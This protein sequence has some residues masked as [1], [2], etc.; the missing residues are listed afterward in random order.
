MGGLCGVWLCGEQHRPCTPCWR[1]VSGGPNS[2]FIFFISMHLLHYG[3]NW[4][5][6]CGQHFV[7][8]C[9]TKVVRDHHRKRKEVFWL[10]V[11]KL[12]FPYLLPTTTTYY[13]PPTT[14]TT[15]TSYQLHSHAIVCCCKCLVDFD[16]VVL[17]CTPLKTSLSPRD[18]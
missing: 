10:L 4:Q 1:P 11:K 18:R 6:C 3:T 13:L 16:V 8:H 15:T 5:D 14:T 17:Y 12:L 9:P 7:W 2:T